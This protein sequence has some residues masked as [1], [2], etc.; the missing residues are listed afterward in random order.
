MAGWKRGLYARA[1]GLAG[2][3]K[4]SSCGDCSLTAGMPARTTHLC[5]FRFIIYL[6]SLSCGASCDSSDILAGKHRCTVNERFV[7]EIVFYVM[8]HIC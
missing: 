3:R 6:N 1:G 8:G 7:N 5:H 2:P 4:P